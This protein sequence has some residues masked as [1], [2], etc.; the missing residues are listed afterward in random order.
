MRMKERQPR[1][2]ATASKVS[3]TGPASVRTPVAHR[4]DRRRERRQAGRV[5]ATAAVVVAFSLSAAPALA[6]TAPDTTVKRAGPPRH[7]G[8]ATLVPE[9]TV[10]TVDGAVEY[11]FG[12][13]T[14]ALTLRDGTVLIL[15][16]PTG[17]AP[18]LRQYDGSG[19]YIRMIGRTGE[20][21]GEYRGPSG[22]AQLPDGRI[23]LLDGLNRRINVYTEAGEPAGD[24]S[25]GDVVI[26][27][28]GGGGLRVGRDGTVY[29][30]ARVR[31]A[32]ARIS[33]RFGTVF[34]RFSPDGRIIDQVPEPELPDVGGSIT[35]ST[36]NSGTTVTVPYAPQS[37][38]ALSPLGGFVTGVTTRYAFELRLPRRAGAAPGAPPTWSPA[39][40]V[41][42]VRRDIERVGVSREERAALRSDLEARLERA[43][44]TLNR[45]I[46]EISSTK[47]PYR[48]IDVGDDGRIWIRVSTPSERYDPAEPGSSPGGGV[49]MGVGG[50]STGIRPTFTP[51]A[52][53]PWREPT[54]YDVFEPDGSYVGQVALPYDTRILRMRG[55]TVWGVVTDDLDVP[56]VRRFRIGWR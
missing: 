6:Q 51:I 21:P 9:L 27:F 46:P 17:A 12:R 31:R 13:P 14:E 1:S 50:G 33:E 45:Q 52:P 43:Q 37:L 10:G 49:T 19:R 26:G 34:V 55:D 41:I 30:R 32:G 39:D 48:R 7:A 47:P 16:A 44:G 29:A 24:W 40:G 36:P 28:G 4:R 23:L 53:V 25:V 8:V 20:G 42:S 56:V 15:D 38:S 11:V 18:A 54:R 2:Q 5:R 3:G 22:L 35:K